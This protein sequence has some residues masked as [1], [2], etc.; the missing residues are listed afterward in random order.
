MRMMWIDIGFYNT[1]QEA[2][3]ARRRRIARGEVLRDPA[4][5]IVKWRDGSFLLGGRVVVGPWSKRSTRGGAVR[6]T[7][8]GQPVKSPWPR[9]RTAEWR[10]VQKKNAGVANLQPRR[11]KPAKKAPKIKS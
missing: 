8:T 10:A 3:A 5:I 6:E 4:P 9:K 1:L 11:G 2:R 7:L